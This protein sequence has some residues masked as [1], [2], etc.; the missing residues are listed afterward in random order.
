MV[1][2]T[3]EEYEEIV[4]E[5]EALIPD[6]DLFCPKEVA[7]IVGMSY[8]WV[9]FQLRVGRIDAYRLGGVWRIR[10]SALKKFLIECR[11]RSL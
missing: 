3:D 8:S 1:L 10:R 5:V 11:L 4:R 7:H 2:V 9:C 6:Q